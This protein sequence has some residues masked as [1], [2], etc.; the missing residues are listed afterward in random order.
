MD[1][2]DRRTLPKVSNRESYAQSHEVTLNASRHKDRV[3]SEFAPTIDVVIGGV[4]G[5]AVIRFHALGDDGNDSV[6][7]PRH[8]IVAKPVLQ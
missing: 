2:H 7:D 6:L 3:S 4:L 5:W 1:A 8:A